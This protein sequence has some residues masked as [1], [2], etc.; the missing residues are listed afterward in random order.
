MKMGFNGQHMGF[1]GQ[2]MGF[3]GQHMGFNVQHV[4]FWQPFDNLQRISRGLWWDK[5]WS[6]VPL[7][8][9][10][11]SSSGQGDALDETKKCAVTRR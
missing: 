9:S 3:N 11:S 2:H 10:A 4:G 7:A 5:S 6:F 8:W 1:N